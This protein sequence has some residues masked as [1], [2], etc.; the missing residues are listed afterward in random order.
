MLPHGLCRSGPG[1]WLPPDLTS[2]GISE[3][4]LP[5]LK[6]QV[7]SSWAQEAEMLGNLR[8]TCLLG[9]ELDL[10]FELTWGWGSEK[11]VLLFSSFVDFP[12]QMCSFIISLSS[13]PQSQLLTGPLSK[14]GKGWRASCLGRLQRAQGREGC[15]RPLQRQVIPT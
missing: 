10:G 3:E 8:E 6:R 5:F 14:A 2:W 7:Q 11:A 12:E 13:Q 1:V 4:N 9:L 15:H